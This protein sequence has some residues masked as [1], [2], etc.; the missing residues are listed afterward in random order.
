[1]KASEFRKLIREEIRKVVLEYYGDDR[2]EAN[3]KKVM[4]FKLP[5]LQKVVK[6]ITTPNVVEGLPQGESIS[7]LT[8]KDFEPIIQYA[9]VLQKTLIDNRTGA[10]ARRFVNKFN[11]GDLALTLSNLKRI[12]PKDANVAKWLKE[13]EKDL[14]SISYWLDA[15]NSIIPGQASTY[16][17]VKQVERDPWSGEVTRTYYAPKRD[18]DWTGYDMTSR[19]ASSE[20]YPALYR[21]LIT[22]LGEVFIDVEN[23]IKTQDVKSFKALK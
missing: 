16:P 6:Y 11:A 22:S 7:G 4:S 1:M 5:K 19:A 3:K 18:D 23:L 8:E 10:E 12:K 21:E 20:R 13:L 14:D 9:A 2:R 17:N 15:Y